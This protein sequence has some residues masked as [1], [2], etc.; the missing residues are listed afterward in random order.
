MSAKK[1]KKPCP[2]CGGRGVVSFG[3]EDV[4]CATCDGTGKV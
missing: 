1:P 4:P 3:T 2:D